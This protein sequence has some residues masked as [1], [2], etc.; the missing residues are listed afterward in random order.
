MKAATKA[1][2]KAA[3]RH[4]TRSSPSSTK[5]PEKTSSASSTTTTTPKTE[6][7]IRHTPSRP[8]CPFVSFVDK[9]CPF[10]PTPCPFRQLGQLGQLRA[11]QKSYLPQLFQSWP[12]Y[13]QGRWGSWGRVLRKSVSTPTV[14]PTAPHRHS[15]AEPAL[16]PR[17]GGGNPQGWKGWTQPF[18]SLLRGLTR[19]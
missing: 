12:S 7:D 6:T 1:V 17:H 19:P 3:T 11:A 5:T 2:L 18:S 9:P 13:G 14:I 4:A 16:V 8:S 10:R 15:R